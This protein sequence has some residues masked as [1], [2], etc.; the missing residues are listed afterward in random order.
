MPQLALDDDQRHA[1]ASH[2]H[3]MRVAQLVRREAPPHAGLPREA[4]QLRA[5]RSGRPRPPPCRAGDDAEQR[6]DRQLHPRLD[7]GLKLL[8]RPV[9]HPDLAASP[10]LAAPYQQRAAARV[11]VGLGERE[12]LVDPQAGSPE[13]DD[14]AAQPVA[15]HAVSGAAHHC[16]DLLDRRRVGRVADPLVAGRATRVELRQRGGRATAAGGIEQQLGHDPSSGWEKS[17]DCYSAGAVR[18]PPNRHAGIRAALRPGELDSHRRAKA[19]A[20]CPNDY[21]HRE[22]PSAWEAVVRRRRRRR[23]GETRKAN[24]EPS[25][26]KEANGPAVGVRRLTAPVPATRAGRLS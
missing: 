13:H 15:V 4:S 14:Q 20:R 11:Q 26:L 5:R 8:P 10:A 16:H 23:R 17:R 9:V 3:G 19:V 12:R 2:L 24:L 18:R 1:L 21:R 7:P 6:S 22:R 25:W